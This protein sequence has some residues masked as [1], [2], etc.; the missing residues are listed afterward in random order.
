M[1]LIA[2]LAFVG[3]KYAQKVY[4]SGTENYSNLKTG[5]SLI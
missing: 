4:E 5:N 1:P 3:S 2:S